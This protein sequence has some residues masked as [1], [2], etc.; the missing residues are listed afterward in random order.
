MSTTALIGLKNQE[1]ITAICVDFNGG[2]IGSE[3]VG[4]ILLNN[5]N[6][7]AK[8]HE[9]FAMGDCIKLNSTIENSVFYRRD[10][11]EPL[12][13]TQSEIYDQ[14]MWEELM[15]L[16]SNDF[17]YLYD[18]KWNLCSGKKVFDL[19]QIIESEQFAIAA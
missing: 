8:I 7:I 11:Q 3:C 16:Q 4:Y 19:A 13:N 2:L 10:R 12:G 9:L 6:T 17:F 1:Q 15:D 5:Y 14:S 18:G